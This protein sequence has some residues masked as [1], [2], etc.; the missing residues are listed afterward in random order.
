MTSL[1]AGGLSKKRNKRKPQRATFHLH[2]WHSNIPE[3]EISE[4]AEN[5]DELSYAKQQLGVK[6]REC[7]LLG[8]KW[9]KSTDEILQ[10]RFQKKL[11][12]LLKEGFWEK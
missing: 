6:S 9:N 7:G 10:S 4:D 2:K 3:L 1:L 12:N 8:L 11:F 5:E